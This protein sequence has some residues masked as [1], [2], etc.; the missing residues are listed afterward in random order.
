MT[1]FTNFRH[2]PLEIVSREVS[3]FDGNGHIDSNKTRQVY[4][5][6]AA[7]MWQ[8]EKDNV[9]KYWDQWTASLS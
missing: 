1:M 8:E 9:S 4:A 2:I 7:T 3:M 6:A 5:E